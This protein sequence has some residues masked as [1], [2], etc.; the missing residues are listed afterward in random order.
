MCSLG[1]APKT[2]RAYEFSRQ[3]RADVESILDRI[4]ADVPATADAVARRL[5]STI[6]TV[7]L[8]PRTGRRTNIPDVWIFGGTKSQPFRFTFKVF[9]DRIL[10][11]RVFRHS[12]GHIPS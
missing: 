5:Q 7:C 10:V 8:F 2:M 9:D 1:T 6:E 4:Q 12:R 11:L 3:A